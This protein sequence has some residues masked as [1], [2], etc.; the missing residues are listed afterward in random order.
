MIVFGS[1][2]NPWAE[3]LRLD[4]ATEVEDR[5][6]MDAG[7][8]HEYHRDLATHTDEA[9]QSLFGGIDDSPMTAPGPVLKK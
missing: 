4:L 6:L 1:N 7:Q 2:C 8:A 5:L 9:L 3:R